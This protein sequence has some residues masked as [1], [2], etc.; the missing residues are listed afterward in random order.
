MT[1]EVC[2]VHGLELPPLDGFSRA[3]PSWMLGGHP[4]SALP[5][6]SQNESAQELQGGGIG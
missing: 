2:V 6:C 1:D 5:Y 3:K 4:P